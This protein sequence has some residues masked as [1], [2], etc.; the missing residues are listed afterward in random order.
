MDTNYLFLTIAC[1]AS[2][3]SARLMLRP[4]PDSRPSIEMSIGA[5]ICIAAFGLLIIHGTLP[6]ILAILAGAI[7]TGALVRRLSLRW[8]LLLLSTFALAVY[9]HRASIL[10]V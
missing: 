9:L 5:T 8:P 6:W 4:V 7:T 2:G 1:A 10:L 3:P